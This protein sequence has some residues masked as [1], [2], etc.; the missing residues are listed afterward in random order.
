MLD[1][2]A[3]YPI[4]QSQDRL[5]RLYGRVAVVLLFGFGQLVVRHQ[6]WMLLGVVVPLRSPGPPFGQAPLRPNV[7][8]IFR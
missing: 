7:V 8:G 5:Q 6:A 1:L 3:L 4:P 2:S